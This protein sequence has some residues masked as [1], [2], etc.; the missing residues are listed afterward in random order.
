M[1]VILYRSATEYLPIIYTRN[2]DMAYGILARLG[3]SYAI[4]EC[5]K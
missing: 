4:Y 5:S 1:Y 3:S 2:R